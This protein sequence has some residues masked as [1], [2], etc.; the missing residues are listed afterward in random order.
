MA[1]RKNQIP[2]IYTA[3]G[4]HFFEGSP[5]KNWLFYPIE[6]ILSGYTDVLVTINQEDYNRANEH[7]N[8]KNIKYIPGVGLNT[9]KFRNAVIDRKALRSEIEVPED[10][11]MMFSVGEI[12]SRKNHETAIRALAKTVNKNLYYA[13]CGQGELEPYLKH[14]TKELGIENRVKF[15]GFRKDIAQLCKSIRYLCFF[16]HKEKD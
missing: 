16:H 13:I 6:K 1:A 3:H 12:S 11:I 9:S 7:F 8:M 14:L 15:L 10:A 5:M 4:F 2:I